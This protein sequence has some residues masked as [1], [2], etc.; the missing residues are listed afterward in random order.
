MQR[1]TCRKIA[2]TRSPDF[3]C[4]PKK[5]LKKKTLRGNN[6]IMTN[7]L[8]L[9]ASRCYMVKFFGTYFCSNRFF[10]VTLEE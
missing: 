5:I 2:V 8:A 3:F 9:S 10:Q 7:V 6:I 4:S 1:W